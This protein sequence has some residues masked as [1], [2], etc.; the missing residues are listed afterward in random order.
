M[1]G[2][3]VVNHRSNRYLPYKFQTLNLNSFHNTLW[4]VLC[5]IK[6]VATEGRN[7]IISYCVC[8]V[9]LF[10]LPVSVT[11]GTNRVSL[12]QDFSYENNKVFSLINIVIFLPVFC[13]GKVN[14][15]LRQ[16]HI[17]KFTRY[18]SCHHTYNTAIFLCLKISYTF[19]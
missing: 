12:E 19:T 3:L 18:V 15:S 13:L 17:H 10:Y 5:E 2:V 14:D 6:A 1:K 16:A 11:Y 7:T 8:I 9:D 4:C